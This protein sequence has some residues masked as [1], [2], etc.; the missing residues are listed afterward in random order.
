MQ[1]EGPWV[2]RVMSLEYGR[3]Y[4]LRARQWRYIVD[5]SGTEGLYDLAH[6]PGE[7]A[8]LAGKSPMALRFFRDVAGFFLAH[9]SRW[10]LEEWGTFD[11]H[12]PA[13]AKALAAGG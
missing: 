8:D 11:N 1:R 5:Y 12:S 9:R 6:D 4:S 13:F 10:H 7:Q 2:P 3:S